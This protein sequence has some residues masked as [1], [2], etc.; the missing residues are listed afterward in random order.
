LRLS[1]AR[2]TLTKLTRI[3][4]TLLERCELTNWLRWG[5]KCTYAARGEFI[6]R[7]SLGNWVRSDSRNK[8]RLRFFGDLYSSSHTNSPR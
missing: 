5:R 4:V 7:T 6:K 3:D 8:S 1:I 2:D